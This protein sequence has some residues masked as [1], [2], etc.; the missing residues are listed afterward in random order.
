MA[1]S[2]VCE[3]AETLSN[4]KNPE[5]YIC[6][7]MKSMNK[8]LLLI[9]FVFLAC[10]LVNAQQKF[11][12][13]VSKAG[14]VKVKVEWT[15]PFGDSIVQL[16]IQRSWD[17][18]KNFRTVFVPLSLSFLK[19]DTLMKPLGTPELLPCLLCACRW[20]LFLFSCKKTYARN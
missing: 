15:N 20:Q 7:R 10:G 4:Y 13:H 6:A 16:N 19:M 9:L 1:D 17:S 18:A 3:C 5:H 12:L 11:Q 2:T 14:D 8:L